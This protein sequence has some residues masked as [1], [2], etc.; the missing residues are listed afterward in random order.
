MHKLQSFIFGALLLGTM[1]ACNN[2]IDPGTDGNAVFQSN[3]ADINNYATSKGLMGTLFNSGLYYVL[4]KPGSSTVSPAVGQEVEFNFT[5]YAL[6]RSTGNTVVTDSF[7]DSTYKTKSTYGVITDGTLGLVEGLMKMH[8]GDQS[9]FLLPS[10]L[11]FGDQSA[12]NGKVPANAAV[13][14]DIT[15]KRTRTEDQQID[16]YLTANK[17]T[18]SEVSTTGLRFIKTVTN[19]TGATPTSTQTLTIRYKGKLLRSASAFDST[20]TGTYA[21]TLGNFVPGFSEG[22]AKLKVGEQAT[23]IFPSKVG[24]GSAG[25]SVIPPYAPLRFDIELVSVQ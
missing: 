15:L 17:L 12:Y 19:S 5:L 23:I 22:L 11:A 2:N 20:G 6:S 25:R 7:A 24:Y 8:E 10:A 9:T 1:A 4:N 18:P 3:L 21:G 16:E 13:R 14:F